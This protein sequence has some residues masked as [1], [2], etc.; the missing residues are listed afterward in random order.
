MVS[1]MNLKFI[2]PEYVTIPVCVSLYNENVKNKKPTE[3]Y[4]IKIL[5]TLKFLSLTHEIKLRII[6]LQ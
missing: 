6:T 5:V 2:I 4:K 3:T 1:M